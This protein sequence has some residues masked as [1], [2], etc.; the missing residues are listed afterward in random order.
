MSQVGFAAMQLNDKGVQGCSRIDTSYRSRSSSSSS[1]SPS[2]RGALTRQHKNRD[3]LSYYEITELLGS[4][5]VGSVVKV[6]KKD[7]VIGGSARYNMKERRRVHKKVQTCFSLPLV[8]GFFKHCLKGQV[9]SLLEQASKNSFSSS[10]SLFSID[11]TEASD[12]TDSDTPAS[13]S[14]E[15]VY[16]MKS[17]HLKRFSD[18]VY[19]DE[20]KNE[21]EMLKTLDHPHI[22]RLIET[23]DYNKQ[24][25]L[26]ME[27]CSGGDLYTRDPYTEEQAAR[28]MYSI[29]SAVAYMHDHGV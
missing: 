23:F 6:R 21:V 5:S 27:I 7:A 19:I 24:L 1:K 12:S 8:G 10:K 17:I 29:L 16:A 13:F 3:P 14:Y 4:G 9:D 28:I 25:F 2:L 18:P 11:S 15:I 26:L 22:V 20:L